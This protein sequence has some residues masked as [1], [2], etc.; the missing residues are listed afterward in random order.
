MKIFDSQPL[1]TVAGLNFTKKDVLKS[2]HLMILHYLCIN[3]MEYIYNHKVNG[4]QTT[5]HDARCFRHEGG[6]A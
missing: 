4:Q 5:L 1:N 6:C 3:K 2:L